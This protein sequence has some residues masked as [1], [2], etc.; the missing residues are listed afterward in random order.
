[1]LLGNLHDIWPLF[2]NPQFQ[3]QIISAR[4]CSHPRAVKGYVKKHNKWDF[5]FMN[6]VGK[7][8]GV[9]TI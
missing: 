7:K 3:K 8:G 1:M 4:M 6:T 9:D 2:A 5:V